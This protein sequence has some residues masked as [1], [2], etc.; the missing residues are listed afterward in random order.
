MSIAHQLAAK[1][2][3]LYVVGVEPSILPFKDF[4]MALAHAAGGRYVPLSN[5]RVLA[6]VSISLFCRTDPIVKAVAQV[7][8]AAVPV[9]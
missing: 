2:V 9:L 4:F 5:A 7:T 6:K 3:T 8:A 1:D